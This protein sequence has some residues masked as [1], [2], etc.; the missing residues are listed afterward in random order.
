[1][2]DTAPQVI[3]LEVPQEAQFNASGTSIIGSP[4]VAGGLPVGSLVYLAGANLDPKTRA[5]VFEVI[6]SPDR[7]SQAQ[8]TLSLAPH[9]VRADHESIVTGEMA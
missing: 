2:L 3:Q 9:L 4:D 5:T 1:M 6:E 8:I 7:P